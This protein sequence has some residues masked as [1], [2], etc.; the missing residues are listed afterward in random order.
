MI[1]LKIEDLLN[2][3]ETI[4]SNIF[5]GYTYAWEVLP[6]LREYIIELGKSLPEDEYLK[7]GE[8]V[9]IS[10][11]AIVAPTASIDGPTIIGHNSEVRHCAYIRGNVII[12]ES[13][14]VGNSTEL[15]NSLLFNEVQVPHFNYVG[16]SILGYKAHIGAGG[17]TSNIKSDKTSITVNVDGKHF[18]T[19]LRKFGTILGDHAEIG[20]NSVLNPGSVVGRGSNVYPLS[21]VRG[22]V[23][24][25]SI[26]KRQGEVVAKR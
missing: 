6:N 3:K 4:A 21:M 15:K 20:S 24:P 7:V 13:T 22:Y 26:Y 14:I 16:D 9:W 10:R 1:D 19:N 2:L 5:D 12:G 8:D 25:N 11:T 23:P 17:I 18:E